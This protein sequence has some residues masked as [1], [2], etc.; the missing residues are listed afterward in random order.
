MDERD[1]AR[2]ILY[3]LALGDAL[4]W[5][6]EFLKMPKIKIIYGDQG[7][8]EPPDPAQVSDETQ[9]TLVIAESLIEA[10]D[11]D[12]DTLMSVV[13]RR[14]I[15][16][17][18]SPQNDRAPGYVVTEAVR[19]L[20]AG[21]SWRESGNTDARGNGSAVRVAPI[22]FLYQHDPERLRAVAHATGIATHAHPITDASAVAAA[23]LVKLALDGIP[24]ND[25]VVRTL[26]FVGEEC[27]ELRDTL[28]KIGHVVE[29]Q[30]EFAAMNYIGSGWNADEAVAMAV[31]CAIRHSSDFSAALC[32]AVNI[33]GDSDSVGC[34]AGGLVAA[35]LG[36]ESIPADWIAR[37]EQRDYITDVALR[38]ADKKKSM[39]GSVYPAN[40][41]FGLNPV[42]L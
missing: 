13:T 6:I 42:D 2:A 24:P 18:N 37:L 29:W 36:L 8:Q 41:G 32:R 27:T 31:Y 33:P 23:Y 28:T 30:D 20:E 7:I 19:T 14:L 15:E 35:R 11:A 1:R 12:L 17:S 3:G 16:W 26:E 21:V 9:T 40:G 25:Y 4:G 10:G 34:V 5:P 38:L 39:Y 22:G